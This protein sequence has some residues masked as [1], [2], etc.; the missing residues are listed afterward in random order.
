MC[1]RTVSEAAKPRKI[2]SIFFFARSEHSVVM[3]M[4]VGVETDEDALIFH[5]REIEKKGEF[6]FLL[7]IFLSFA[8]ATTWRS[9]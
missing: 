3:P 7:I 9:R 6:F 5:V 4:L 8:R 2:D 1:F